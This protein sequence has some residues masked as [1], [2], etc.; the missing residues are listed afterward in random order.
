MGVQLINSSKLDGRIQVE[1][2]TQPHPAGSRRA[3][4]RSSTPAL[5]AGER[6]LGMMT[7]LVLGRSC[8]S[9]KAV[10]GEMTS[11]FP[12]PDKGDAVNLDQWP[13][14]LSAWGGNLHGACQSR[15]G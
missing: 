9:L 12:M 13:C 8:G 11:E 5:A 1:D 6:T 10:L 15:R 3:S 4:E 2:K 14:D 7:Q